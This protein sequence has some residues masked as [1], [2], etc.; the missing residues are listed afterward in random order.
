MPEPGEGDELTQ[1][2][3][4]AELISSVNTKV[5]NA[6]SFT[7]HMSVTDFT[8]AN[9]RAHTSKD[10]D[11]KPNDFKGKHIH[12]FNFNKTLISIIKQ[13]GLLD[14]NSDAVP[15]VPAA[16]KSNESCD[17]FFLHHSPDKE[18][19]AYLCSAGSVKLKVYPVVPS[20]SKPD[21]FNNEYMPSLIP[22]HPFAPSSPKSESVLRDS[23]ATDDD[24]PMHNP[25]DALPEPTTGT[26]SY[27]GPSR[28]SYTHQRMLM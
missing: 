1:L 7:P 6:S 17:V 11:A 24:V 25:N 19:P 16:I 26:I 27:Y 13:A 18:L 22:L 20:T 2:Y 8:N 3:N 28:M 21:L 9:E 5:N 15:P 12:D 14:S 23:R 10:L 4:A